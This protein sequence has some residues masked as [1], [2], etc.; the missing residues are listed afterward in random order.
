MRGRAEKIFSKHLVQ[1]GKLFVYKKFKYA[2]EYG[3]SLRAR[4]ERIQN[5]F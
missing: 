4:E 2:C 5:R 1:T 3:I